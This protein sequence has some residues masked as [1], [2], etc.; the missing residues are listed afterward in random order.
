MTALPQPVKAFLES[1]RIVVAGVS[2]QGN[3]PANLIFR[4][5]RDAGI[6]G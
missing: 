1:R 3:Q 4:R 6:V 2:R 5:L